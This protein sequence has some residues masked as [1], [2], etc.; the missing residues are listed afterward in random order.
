MKEP[1]KSGVIGMLCSALGRPREADVSDLS[2]LKLAVRADREGVLSRD[3]HTALEVPRAGNPGTT[4]VI[5]NR[6]YL[7]DACFLVALEGDEGIIGELEGALRNPHWQ[8]FLGRKAF[9]PSA[10]ILLKADRGPTDCIQ[11]VREHRWLGRPSDPRPASLRAVLESPS[12]DDEARMDVPIS[13]ARR[14]FGLR[15]VRTE[16]IPTSGLLSEA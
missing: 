2:S 9:V 8:L 12:N 1:T 16:W 4:T 11:A 13:F 15:F 14:E 10:P 3:F 5:S 7:A 6:Y